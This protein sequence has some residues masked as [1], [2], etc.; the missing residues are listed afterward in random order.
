MAVPADILQTEIKLNIPGIYVKVSLIEPTL[1]QRD[2]DAEALCKASG[3]GTTEAMLKKYPPYLLPI[4]R[5][6]MA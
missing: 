3:E 1:T 4:G 2:S 6:L 5:Q